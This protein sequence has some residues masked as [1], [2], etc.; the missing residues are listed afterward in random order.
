MHLVA[1]FTNAPTDSVE[2]IMPSLFY[3]KKLKLIQQ[4]INSIITNKIIIFNMFSNDLFD[5]IKLRS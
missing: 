5:H 3:G 1:Y 4:K 2:P